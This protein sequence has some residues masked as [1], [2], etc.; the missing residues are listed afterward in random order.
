MH[1]GPDAGGGMTD[2]SSLIVS[3][4]KVAHRGFMTWKF[5]RLLTKAEEYGFT[6][7]ELGNSDSRFALFM[8]VGRAFEIC[9]HKEVIDYIADAMLGGIGTGDIETRPDY[10]QMAI[11]ALSGLTKLELDLILL[12]KKHGLWARTDAEAID[13]SGFEGFYQEAE[14]WLG[15]SDLETSAVLNSLTKTGLVTPPANGVGASITAQ[16]NKLTHLA[17]ELFR[18]VNHAKRL[19]E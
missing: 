8:R 12:M 13:E 1:S 5:D 19:V 6:E 4:M 11:S 15:L 16:G 18:Y 10:P 7:D 3:G 14:N 9:S 17:D 2:P